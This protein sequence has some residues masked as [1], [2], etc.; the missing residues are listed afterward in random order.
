M[1]RPLKMPKRKGFTLIELLVVIAI[2]AVLVGLLVPAVQK[3]RTA[4][5]SAQSKNNLKQIGLAV[6]NADTTMGKMPMMFGQYGST[7]SGSFWY[8][9]L[10]YIEQDN[11]FKQG[12]NASRS[13]SLKVLQA[14]ND[15][16]LKSGTFELLPAMEAWY[17]SNT[18]TLPAGNPIPA[19]ATG[20]TTWGL[21]SYAANWLVFGDQATPLNSTLADG[22]SNTLIIAE[23]YSV[24]RRPSGLPRSGAMLWG[25]GVQPGLPTDSV[26]LKGKQWIWGALD[27][28]VSWTTLQAHLINAPYWARSIWVNNPNPVAASASYPYPSSTKPWRCRCHRCRCPPR[29]PLRRA[30]SPSQRGTATTTAIFQTRQT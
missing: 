21:S 16:T 3:V 30:A 19:W 14:P 12:V 27:S 8:N 26:P 6:A 4:A 23:H 15:A 13:T 7:E 10:P 5:N 18:A 22:T 17:G 2:I 9:I 20:S 1:F 28:G 11:L 24:C 29:Q 25:Y